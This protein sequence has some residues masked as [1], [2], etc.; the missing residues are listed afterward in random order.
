MEGGFNGSAAW[1]ATPLFL[2]VCLFGIG[3]DFFGKEYLQ[4]CVEFSLDKANNLQLVYLAC[5][6]FL[7]SMMLM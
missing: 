4:G 7:S 2:G 1:V 3:N 6:S 5:A